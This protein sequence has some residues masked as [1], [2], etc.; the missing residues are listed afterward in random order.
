MRK[1]FIDLTATG[2]PLSHEA[3]D[4]AFLAGHHIATGHMRKILVAAGSLPPRDEHLAQIELRL[5]IVVAKYPQFETVLRTYVRWSVLPRLRRRARTRRP[6]DH[7]TEWARAR[8]H[9]AARFLAWSE[10]Q[11]QALDTVT[12]EHVDDWLASGKST[13][14]NV[15]DFLVWAARRGYARKLLVPHRG[16]PDPAGLDEDVHWDVLQQCLHDDQ[17]PLDVKVAGALVHLYAQPLSRIV[18]LTSNDIRQHSGGNNRLLLD[19]QPVPLP[20]PLDTL[21]EQ[22]ATEYGRKDAGTWLFRGSYPGRPM[23]VSTLQRRLNIHG[24]RAKPS[25]VTACLN[26]AQDLPPAVLASI[27]GMHVITAEQWHRRAAPD[28]GAYLA[29]RRTATNSARSE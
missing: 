15:R 10:E 20:P 1:L 27:T 2:K 9:S 24:I 12:Q 17:L 8:I 5:G 21:V 25:R 16:K 19:R 6:T 29:A 4:D 13:Q 3:L 18:A 26:L 7:I 23:P 28:W 14:Y 11:G 22:L